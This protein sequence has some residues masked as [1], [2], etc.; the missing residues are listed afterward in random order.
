VNRIYQRQ[1]PKA[2]LRALTTLVPSIQNETKKRAAITFFPSITNKLQGIFKRHNI[3]L[4]YSIRSKLSDVLGNPKNKCHPLEKSGVTKLHVKVVKRNTPARQKD[5]PFTRFKEHV[6]HIK[7]NHP[8]LSSVASH[9]F[10]H[11]HETNTIIS[12]D[13]LSILREVRKPSQLDAYESIFIQKSNK[14]KG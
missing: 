6:R 3:D 8:Y 4:V 2:E 9:V 7:Y 1:N 10:D 14:V 13:S 5:V 11:I 12:I